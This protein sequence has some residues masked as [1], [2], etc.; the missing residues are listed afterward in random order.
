[1]TDSPYQ[2]SLRVVKVTKK[3]KEKKEDEGKKFKMRVVMTVGIY[4]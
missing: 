3:E 4:K 1:M 2:A